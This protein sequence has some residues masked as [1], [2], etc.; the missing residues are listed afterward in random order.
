VYVNVPQSYV[1][2]VPAGTKARLVVPEHP[3]KTYT[4][5]VEASAGAVN[6]QSGTTLMQ[7][8]VDNAAGELL[9]GAYADVT[10]DLPHDAKALSIPSS[11][12]I[13]DARGLRVATVGDGD[14]VVLKPV[15]IARDF[16]STIQVASGLEASDRVIQNPPD[17]V[18][19]GTAVRIAGRAAPDAPAKG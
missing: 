7:L 5:T 18:T 14:R 9:P 11:A 10:L 12:L 16:G 3:E 8:A 6:A 13:F 4:A 15:T 17:G 1:P 19:D 2:D